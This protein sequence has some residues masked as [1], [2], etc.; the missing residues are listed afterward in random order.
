[1]GD[2][3]RSE[4]VIRHVLPI[5]AIW[6]RPIMTSQCL[7]PLKL[8]RPAVVVVGAFQLIHL[9]VCLNIIHIFKNV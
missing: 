9:N 1:M 7:E 2:Y 6:G 5:L 3:T 4:L 8:E